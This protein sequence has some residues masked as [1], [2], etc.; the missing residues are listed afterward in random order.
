MDAQLN[1]LQALKAQGATVTED[2]KDIGVAIDTMKAAMT[3][4]RL[5]AISKNP[6]AA[7]YIA[8]NMAK[9]A[10]DNYQL[11]KSN[12]VDFDF[13]GQD[14]NDFILKENKVYHQNGNE[15]TA[16]EL[17]KLYEDTD[18]DVVAGFKTS[19]GMK[20]QIGAS[21]AALKSAKQ[22]PAYKEAAKKEAA[23]NK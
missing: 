15:W 14:I 10:K 23:K 7:A 13:N 12:D 20:A 2:G 18:V 5:A 21:K 1:H 22:T 3:N 19:S 16:N 9:F 11:Y 8:Y 17:K 6:D 4:K